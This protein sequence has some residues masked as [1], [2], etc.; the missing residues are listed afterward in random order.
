MPSRKKNLLRIAAVVI[1]VLGLG[2]LY[3]TNIGILSF[4]RPYLYQFS[5]EMSAVDP[6]VAFV[7]VN[8]IPMDGERVLRNQ[9]VLV[10]DGLIEKIGGGVE[11]PAEAL[12][13]DGTG[14]YLMPGLVDM[15]VHV[16]NE[17][18]LLLFVANGVTTVRNMWGMTGA[19]LAFGFPDQLALREAIRKGD[20]F[21]P[22]IYTT[23]PVMEGQPKNHPL[24]QAFITPAEAQT[25][26]NW[27]AGQ[28][29]DFIK[30][31]DHLDAETYR[32]ILGA[33]R[34]RGLPVVGHAPFA[35]GIE[36]VLS[37]GQATIE[38]LTGYIDADAVRFLI[39]EDQLAEYAARTRAARVWNVPT[40]AL[41]P[42][43]G[44]SPTRLRELE[45]QPGM[46]YLSPSRKALN[47]FL[48]S[49]MT[50]GHT[51]AGGDYPE[52]I[53][54]LNLA[55]TRAL[56]EAG[57]GLLLGTDALNPYHLPGYSAHEELGYL[58][59]A[60]LS[61]YEALQAGTHDA[62]LA[63]GKLNEFGTVTEGKRADLILLQQNPLS[64]V[65]SVQTRVGV[66]LRGRW[67]AEDHLQSMLN[68]LAESFKPSLL[69]RLWPLSLIA[70][71]IYLIVWKVRP[72]SRE[73][74]NA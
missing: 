51:Y 48:Y 44:V 55:M 66:M 53:A 45:H 20:L 71:A 16:M 13:V 50:G 67:L 28:G 6:L 31:Y 62:A 52:R 23:G 54:A 22:T 41:Y 60:G 46:A 74:R 18:D 65:S 29:Y 3:L 61:P 33:A 19:S 12:R 4:G 7:N 27:Q 2:L 15:H 11:V 26:V 5:G 34:E 64:D 58:V 17:D 72:F 9:T 10:R 43:N 39:P 47:Q 57:A 14:R 24:M 21:G 59:Q 36:G 73:E 8:V 35:A 25:F 68:A 49:Q 70:V 40:L 63:L 38:H 56:H 69:E 32:A 42:K 30:V 1:F 37:G